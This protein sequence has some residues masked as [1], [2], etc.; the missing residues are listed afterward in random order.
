MLHKYGTNFET[1]CRLFHAYELGALT[2][3][4][5]TMVYQPSPALLMMTQDAMMTLEG[6]AVRM[7]NGNWEVFW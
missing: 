2:L 4:P 1:F 6:R 5:I 3:R 7:P